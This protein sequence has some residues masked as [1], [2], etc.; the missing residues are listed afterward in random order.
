MGRPPAARYSGGT[1]LTF[2]QPGN[3]YSVLFAGSMFGGF[4]GS[5]SDM[6]SFLVRMAPV[7]TTPIP[8]ALPLFLF[9]LG[10]LGVIARRKKT[11]AA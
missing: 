4:E 11:A 9:A 3:V 7:A 6:S 2:A 5:A 8:A 10:G 1:I